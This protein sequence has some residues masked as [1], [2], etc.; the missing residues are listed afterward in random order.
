MI[1]RFGRLSLISASTVTHLFAFSPNSTNQLR[2][3]WSYD[4]RTIYRLLPLARRV[5][6]LQTPDRGPW[7]A[8]PVFLVYVI[9]HPLDLR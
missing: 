2:S 7:P 6:A 3:E 5:V 9:R 8:G 1:F 4:L